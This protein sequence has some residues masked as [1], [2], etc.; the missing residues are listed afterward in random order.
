[1]QAERNST[2]E[3][4][5]NPL[6]LTDKLDVNP[7]FRSQE[8]WILFFFIVG[9]AAR[10]VRYFLMFPLWEDESFI[11][12]NIFN[13]S[14][15]ELLQPL[16]YHQVAPV[17]YFWLGKA[18]SQIF[19]FNELSLRLPAFV[20]SIASMFLFWHLC[21]R[22][23]SGSARVFALAFF[24]VS[25]PNLRYSAEFKTYGTDMFVSLVLIVLA[26]EWLRQPENRKWLIYMIL[27]SPIAIGM[28]FPAIF[29][30]SGLSLLMLIVIMKEKR[31]RTP[32]IYWLGF[33]I[34]FGLSFILMFIFCIKAQKEAEMGFMGGSWSDTFPPL[35]PIKLIWWIITSHTGSTFGHPIGGENFGSSA[36][37]ILLVAGLLAMFKRGRWQIA[38]L[39]LCPL[40]MNFAA[41]LVHKFPYGGHVKFSMYFAPMLNIVIG[42]GAAV[43]LN[44]HAGRAA[45]S[46]TKTVTYLVLGGLSL[47]AIGSAA[48]D[49]IHPYKN[50]GD[51]RMRAF[52]KWFWYNSS[53]ASDAYCIKDDLGISFSEKTWDDLGWSAMYL[54]NKY[55]YKP[56]EMVR[57]PFPKYLPKDAQGNVYF[58]LYR[59]TFNKPEANDFDQEKFDQWFA[60]TSEKYEF[61]SKESYPMVR[62]D[63]KERKVFSVDVIGI[64][65][66]RQAKPDLN[67]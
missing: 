19:G 61:V 21:K 2:V 42:M 57:E 33:N 62:N 39:L 65:K 7:A 4:L 46:N 12:V 17:L 32:L 20:T 5:N 58:V 66:F 15:M 30:A 44:G 48:N 59:K 63:K 24:A 22:M 43:L 55:I 29:T 26:V 67:K 16:D 14:Y 40:A 23:L 54:A 41:A 6:Y 52:S 10:C 37:A 35:N 60:E 51:E 8:K 1:M 13:R 3:I 47:I 9:I 25:Y 38:A 31:G 28:S 53:F 36:T 56:T 45:E 49:V 34:V 50:S 11:A 27:W 64:Y 18:C